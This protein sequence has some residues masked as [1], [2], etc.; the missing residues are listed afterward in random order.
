MAHTVK[1][2]MSA[3]EG[4]WARQTMLS[5]GAD[6]EAADAVREASRILAD[7]EPSDWHAKDLRRSADEVAIDWT[8]E[9]KTRYDLG[10]VCLGTIVVEALS[11]FVAGDGGATC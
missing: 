8:H 1:A 11:A 10:T 6:P 3:G 5:W 7:V 9:M 2:Y 4:S